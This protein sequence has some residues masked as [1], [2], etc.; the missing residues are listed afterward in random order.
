MDGDGGGGG[1]NQQCH[2]HG[3]EVETR[4]WKSICHSL[5]SGFVNAHS[6][7]SAAA[8]VATKKMRNRSVSLGVPLRKKSVQAAAAAAGHHGDEQTPLQ[9]MRASVV[10]LDPLS[11]GV[12]DATLRRFLV[13][14]SMKVDKATTM[15]VEHQRWRR[16]L[17]FFTVP[18]GG[19]GG[20]YIPEAQVKKE[21][22][23]GKVM[24]AGY[25]KQGHPVAVGFGAKHD[26][27]NRDVEEFKRF[28]VYVFDKLIASMPPGTEKFMFIL[29]LQ[30]VSYRNMDPVAMRTNLDFLQA[31]Y[32]ERLAKAFVV[33]VPTIFWGVWHMLS[34]FI[35]KVTR[36]KIL[37]VEDKALE[38]TL[39]EYIDKEQ[40][41]SLYGGRGHLQS[42]TD[43]SPTYQSPPLAIPEFGTEAAAIS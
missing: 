13:A 7:S 20:G 23:T 3:K 35:D 2:H 15:F 37:F 34:P 9:L 43:V 1:E 42:M 32:P 4:L 39:M 36:E 25:G 28:T 16:S 38:M 33:H 10:E 17:F 18:A 5:S 8:A 11:K 30:G 6:D 29:D 41:P 24:R 21:L 22:E 14:R 40:L 19:G 12:D 26:V 27:L 31:Y